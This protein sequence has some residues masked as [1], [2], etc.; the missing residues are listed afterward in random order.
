MA[1]VFA[2]TMCEIHGIR[3]YHQYSWEY[4]SHYARDNPQ[5][6]LKAVFRVLADVE[7]CL[8]RAFAAKQPR[9]EE[10]AA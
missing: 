9:K 10:K 4:I 1:E 2:A 8:Q 5:E 6:A 7:E 3:G